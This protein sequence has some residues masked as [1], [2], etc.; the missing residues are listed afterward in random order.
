MTWDTSRRC[1]SCGQ[2]LL[3]NRQD[4]YAQWDPEHTFP[5]AP[6]YERLGWYLWE[7]PEEFAVARAMVEYCAD[8]S[9]IWPSVASVARGS[10]LSR[11]TVQRQKNGWRGDSKHR[12]VRGLIPAGVLIEIAPASPRH[13][14]PATYRLNEA[15]LELDPLMRSI[16]ERE[17]QMTLAGVRRRPAPGE[18]VQPAGI[19]PSTH[20]MPGPNE[21]AKIS[22]GVEPE[23]LSR[24]P[25]IHRTLG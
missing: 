12:P 7:S 23:L 19:A 3:E 20:R 18:R 24:Y 17:A 22:S 10:R 8:G 21:P 25:G 4:L 15:A 6:L 5:P 1:K 11:T 14:R 2:P 16:L 13:N 9:T